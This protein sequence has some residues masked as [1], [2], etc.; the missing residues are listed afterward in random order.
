MSE[1]IIDHVCACALRGISE[2]FGD[3]LGSTVARLCLLSN[4]TAHQRI[5]L[6]AVMCIVRCVYCSLFKEFGLCFVVTGLGG[7]EGLCDM[8]MACVLKGQ[9]VFKVC[10][11]TQ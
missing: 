8:E 3:R 6:H 2:Q 1:G 7:E 11:Y 5:N 9:F 10:F 4:K